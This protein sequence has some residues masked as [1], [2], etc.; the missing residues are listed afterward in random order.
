MQPPGGDIKIEFFSPALGAVAQYLKNEI[1]RAANPAT[2]EGANFVVTFRFP[3]ITA[4]LLSFRDVEC[5]F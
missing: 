3:P 1:A 5:V 2:V 4:G